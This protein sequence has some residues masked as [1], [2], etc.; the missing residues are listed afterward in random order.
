MTISSYNGNFYFYTAIPTLAGGGSCNAVVCWNIEYWTSALSGAPQITPG[1]WNFIQNIPARATANEP[2]ASSV[3]VKLLPLS[4]S[5]VPDGVALADWIGNDVS[6]PSVAVYDPTSTSFVLWTNNAPPSLPYEYGCTP[7]SAGLGPGASAYVLYG[8]Q[9][10]VIA[11][12]GADGNT[13]YF[14]GVSSEGATAGDVIFFQFIYNSNTNSCQPVIDSS[15]YSAVQ[16][17]AGGGTTVPTSPVPGEQWRIS[18]AWQASAGTPEIT[19]AFG[20]GNDLGTAL[21]T[22]SAGAWG[23][24]V[25]PG[26]VTGVQD[27]INGLTSTF[28]AAG[29]GNVGTV[30]VEESAANVYQVEFALI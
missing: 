15:S 24:Y 11:G 5:G 3:N 29:G 21:G 4:S 26:G 8:E 19:L 9:S 2:G 12:T 13:L 1:A 27:L 25:F 30:W 7:T 20:L 6:M 28:T 22:F 23:W 10:D 17:V 18:L 14:A 16:L